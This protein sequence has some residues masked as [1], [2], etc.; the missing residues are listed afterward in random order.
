MRYFGASSEVDAYFIAIS[1]ILTINSLMQGG[2]LSEVFL[3][4][5][6]KIKNEVSFD[7]AQRTFF[8]ILHRCFLICLFIIIILWFIAPYF[9]GFIGAGLSAQQKALGTDIFRY[10]SFLILFSILNSFISTVLTAERVYGRAEV[11]HFLN[12]LCS[13]IILYLFKDNLGIY[14]LVIAILFGKIIESI[15]S[16]F[17]LHRAG[18]SYQLSWSIDKNILKSLYSTF[19]FT[20]TY[21][22]STQ[23][24]GIITNYYSSF[25]PAGT[26]SIFNYA[27][28]LMTKASTIFLSPISNIF[29]SEF[30]HSLSKKK[31]EIFSK[32]RDPLYVI[33]LLFSFFTS[34]IIL[35]GNFIFEI[36]WKN[37]NHISTI[38]INLA[39]KMLLLN[40]IGQLF[41]STQMVFRKSAI[42]FGQANKL[43]A[44]WAIAQLL[45]ALYAGIS[46]K[47]FGITG[48]ATVPVFNLIIMAI[49]TII[50]AEKSN[51]PA[52]HS[53]INVLIKEKILFFILLLF[54]FFIV[55]NYLFFDY[56]IIQITVYLL[57]STSTMF[58][59]LKK[60]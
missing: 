58:Y 43:Y 37:N 35:Y 34:I 15:I 39:H 13:V 48:L 24:F 18:I 30:N 33:I 41:F 25:L 17:F 53:L 46:I 7:A 23:I 52:I 26:I 40:F 36:T 57:L 59:Y 14:V 9:V 19:S 22:L 8:S 32:I 27:R 4:I 31:A 29:F 2:Q 10:S 6:I 11:T 44:Q 55:S 20:S 16:F 1:G 54:L 21:A 50:V 51:I 45:S 12:S 60:L 56:F 42:A 3:P 28:Q 47:Y 49:C 38:D 5:Y